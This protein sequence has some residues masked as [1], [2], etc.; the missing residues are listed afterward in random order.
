MGKYLAIRGGDV[1]RFSLENTPIILSGIAFGP[2]AGAVVGLIADI[3]GCI[4]VGY[5]I[6]PI[7]ALGAAAIGLVSGFVP[8]ILRKININTRLKLAI[9]VAI[10]HL[11]GSVVIKTV[12][13]S[14]YYDMPF[15]ILLLWRVLNYLIVGTLDGVVVH[16]LLSH[17][18]I[19]KQIKELTKK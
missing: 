1:M 2:G 8:R 10:A 19:D 9:T 12:G 15:V 17:K 6:N 4:M 16:I 11:V 5:T 18:E 14:A 7:V 13:L 3:V